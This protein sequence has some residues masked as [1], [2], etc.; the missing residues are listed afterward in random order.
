MNNL[1][2]SYSDLERYAEAIKL[3]EETLALRQAKL[4]H[5]HPD[6]LATMHNLAASYNDVGRYTEACKLHERTLQ[7]RKA[8]LGSYHPDTLLTMHALALDYSNLKRHAAA[9]KLR[10]ETLALRKATLGPHHPDTLWSMHTL[11][12]TYSCL[13]Q[14]ADAIK[15]HEETLAL[16]KAVLGPDHPDTFRSMWGLVESLV[17]AGRGAEA[18]PVIDDCV[19]RA[20]KDVSPRLRPSMLYLRLRHFEKVKDKAGCEATARMWENLK[21]TDAV[22]L[23]DAAC[24]WA[25][26]AA[27]ARATNTSDGSAKQSAAAAD[28][29]MAL[30][31]QAITAGYRNF[32]HMKQDGDLDVLRARREFQDLFA[33]PGTPATNV[34]MEKKP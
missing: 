11:A 10:E 1:A 13:N 20:G 7:L 21:P 29:A 28:H 15:L 2:S 26:T 22:G 3:E 32:N 34:G 24:M 6:T 12:Y 14:H 30:L 5:E 27:V 16:R 31:K 25:V 17:M 9:K 4:G 19:A 23:Y 8:K 18:V 33:A